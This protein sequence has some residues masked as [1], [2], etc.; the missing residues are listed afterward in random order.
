MR[1]I[2]PIFIVAFAAS[3]P[4][5]AAEQI[6]VPHFDSVELK[7]GGDLYIVAGPVQRVTVLNGSSQLTS[8]RVRRQGQL[9]IVTACDSRC[10]H[11]YN[12]RIQVE[13]PQVPDVAVSQGGTI[14]AQRG[15]GLQQQISA[16]VSEG[17]T[18]DLRA[19][20]A[21]SVSAAVNAGGDIFVR[22]RESLS[23][24]VHNG[25]DV[26]YSGH[27]AVSMAVSGGGDVRRDD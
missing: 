16:A 26:H 18:I 15:F 6:P 3:A 23:A 10:P 19:V 2:V 1:S 25:G 7:G 22:A 17:G 20:E 13:S 24:A 12:L 9:E 14:V 21:E 4:A 5:L 11:N 27:P 8:F